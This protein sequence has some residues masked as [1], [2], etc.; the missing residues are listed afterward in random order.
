MYKYVENVWP[1]LLVRAVSFQTRSTEVCK[2]VPVDALVEV[3]LF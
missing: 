2:K 3:D 1:E